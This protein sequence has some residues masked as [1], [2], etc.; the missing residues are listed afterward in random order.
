MPD[1]DDLPG[2][3]RPSFSLSTLAGLGIANAISLGVGLALGH[4][5]DGWL[6]SA[7]W[8]VLVGMVLGLTVGAVGSV[9]EIKRYL[10]D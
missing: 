10:Q 3:G 7:P 5:V 8:G 1:H 2:S 4:F 6:G 9:M